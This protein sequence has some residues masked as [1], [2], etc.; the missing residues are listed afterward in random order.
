M[1]RA[2]ANRGDG[3]TEARSRT[4]DSRVRCLHTALLVGVAYYLGALIGFALTFPDEA[5]STL[6][7]PNAIVLTALLLAS[8]SE[9]WIVLSGAFLG[10]L[11][12]QL[13]SG[14]PLPM[15]LGWFVSNSTEAVFGA[16][17]IRRFTK[18]P[19]DFANL[20][21]VTVYTGFAVILAPVLSS[22]LDAAFVVLVGW[23]NDTYWEVW[24]MRLPSNSVAAITIPPFF[25]LWLTNGNVW[26]RSS[27][28]RYLEAASLV[29]GLLAVSFAVFCQAA[30]GPETTP[31]LVYLPLP[32]LLWAA[33]RF[34]PAGA[35]ATILLVALSSICGA[36][37]G[38]GPFTGISVAEN[39][40]SLQLFLIAVS[41]PMLFLAALVEERREKMKV[42]SESEARFR[43]MADTAPVLIW[44]S[45]ADKLYTF[46]N[47]V[48]LEFT[49][50][51]LE[52]ELGN[53]WAEGVHSED[54]RRCMETSTISFDSRQEFTLEYRLRR[55][56]G[57]YRWILTNG[58]PRFAADGSFL[59]YIG[60]AVDLTERKRAE[61]ALR[62]SEQCLAQT[63]KVSL[64]MVTHTDLEGRW[65]KVPP[66][67]C[68]LL[69]YTEEEL[70]G[71]S[72][73]EL[74]H[75]DDVDL[76][77]RQRQRLIRGEIKSFDLEKRYLRKDRSIVWVY[78]NVTLVTDRDGRP[79][80]CL[81]YIR[82]ITER[83]QAEEALH[84]SEKRY[85]IVAE[86]AS[87]VIV[88]IDE[89]ST[90][91]FINA[92]VERVFGYTPKELIGRKLTVLMPESLRRRHEEGMHR[93]LDT[94]KRTFSWN[95]ASFPGMHKSGRQI[96]VDL[97]F[98]ESR[99]GHRRLFTGIIRDV[100]ERSRAESRRN[101][102]HAVT[103]ILSEAGSIADATPRLLQSICECLDWK[104]AE[105]WRVDP[106][107]NL[108]T[109]RETWH[110]PSEDLAGFA[111]AS[112][113][114]SF[115]PGS[116]LPGR[117][118][119]SG[120]PA[121]ISD[122]TVDSNFLRTPL[123]TKAGLHS[124]F[125][126]PIVLADE[127]LGIMVF[128]S[129]EIREADE[130]L[131]QLIASIGSQIGQF[132]ERKRAEEALR[133]SE[134]RLELGMEA[135]RFGYWEVE[136]GTRKV[137]RSPS[138]EQML[139]MHGS[140]ANTP[141]AFFA[142][143]H[144]EDRNIP[145]RHVQDCIESQGSRDV[146]YRIIRPDGRIRWIASRGQAVLGQDGRVS[147]VLGMAADIT[148]RKRA[149]EALRQSEF[150]L[151]EAQRLARL[152]SWSFDIATRTVRWSEE[153]Y[154]IFDFE[155]TAFD[156][157][158]E[159]FLSRVH[160]DDR[161]RVLQANAEAISNGEPFEVEYRITLRGNQLKHIREVG[162]PRKD[163]AGTV[164]GLFGTA[165]DV[166]NRKLA[167]EELREA[168][169]EVG[170]LK[171]RLEADNIY[172]REEVSRSDRYGKV[173]GESSAMRKI[174]HQVDQVS[175][176]D[177]T[178]LVL[179]ETGTGKEL[180]ARAV[181]ERS[182]RRERPLVKVNCTTLPAELIESELFGHEKGAFTGATSR[183]V[184][185]FELADGATIF[186]DE[187]GELPVKLQAKLLRVLQEGEFERLGS[188]KTIKVNV[189]VI[190]ATNRDLA[191]E[192]QKQRFRQDLYYRLNV[193]PI[194]IP[195]LRARKEDIAL[196]AEVF[197][198][199]AT[200]RLG[201]PF[202]AVP[203][204]V[205]EALKG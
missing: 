40:L 114:F 30:P 110:S 181:H 15:I 157:T 104:F 121:W 89:T 120:S 143:V 140:M 186:L 2:I 67:L 50:R 24:R 127:T 134:A 25:V 16:F 105:M 169:T 156:G 172:L 131:L 39:V 62:E 170:R 55:Y 81:S 176:T 179:G 7:P 98:A 113:E 189:R 83:K 151:A 34:G 78:V 175:G 75:P 76:N 29:C 153:L 18:G 23:K 80:H 57:E 48:W 63:E 35:S 108:L 197:L 126:F 91:L 144:P 116:G 107:T 130:N 99:V 37:R 88:T 86:S 97:S 203:P 115:S 9:W 165:Q 183:Q 122:L 46:F 41:L 17:C 38:G 64:V 139:G 47:K 138:F 28:W 177:M 161:T 3:L 147:R 200:T 20:K 164:S 19:V 68:E 118:W 42:L 11:I 167:E 26:L 162:Y 12:V 123:T 74:T 53:G 202:E 178:V 94:D 182:A 196:L 184:G 84:E 102:Q 14:I 103:R 193:Y 174:L 92:A 27:V 8:T 33:I 201:R 66:T 171:E 187:V 1:F 111:S 204:E 188:G 191:K 52:Q 43:T 150:E 95:S 137:T 93:Y 82:D 71:R 79:V 106:Q 32:F 129:H 85:R 132:V 21:T 142:M 128:F 4:I 155:K 59:G 13:Q 194:E 158:Y 73:Q 56:D 185:R 195:P 145:F 149:E 159:T 72:F 133:E 22:F 60:C 135:A 166:T 5:V 44:M 152:G 100:T 146:E 45:G 160:P 190:A 49:G 148:E 109:C 69:G 101:T 173:V 65:L 87:D 192:V 90:I 124:A 31:A 54:S 77:W 199:E 36:F 10:H 198:R 136:V 119:K 70:L 141:E 154:R 58:I 180:V 163:S 112:R 205:I 96:F 117:V 51:N 168:L 125:A 6:W 61:D